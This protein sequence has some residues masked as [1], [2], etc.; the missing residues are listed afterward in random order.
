MAEHTVRD[1]PAHPT[2]G[3]TLPAPLFSGARTPRSAAAPTAAH[4]GTMSH[5]HFPESG[6]QA[7]A[8]SRSAGQS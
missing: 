3:A 7:A 5:S 2:G 6:T 4:A 8:V 1:T